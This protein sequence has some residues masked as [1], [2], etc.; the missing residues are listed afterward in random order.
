M[1]CFN[2]LQAGSPY[3]ADFIVLLFFKKSILTPCF[4]LLKRVKINGKGEKKRD[5]VCRFTVDQKGK[6]MNEKGDV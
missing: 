4:S 3:R 6:K 5:F 2:L 1:D